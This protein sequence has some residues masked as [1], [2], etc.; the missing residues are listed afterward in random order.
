MTTH[1]PGNVHVRFAKTK[2]EIASA[3]R[4]RFEVFSKE[5]G[6]QLPSEKDGFDIDHFDPYCHHL[7][8][9][10]ALNS[11]VIGTYRILPPSGA[12]AAGGYYIGQHYDLT[13]LHG[14]ASSLIEVGRVCVH[15]DYRASQALPLLWSGLA[16]YMRAHN[17]HYMIG[18]GSIPTRYGI[19]QALNVYQQLIEKYAAPKP[20]RL[21]ALKK[22]AWPT[23][24]APSKA[25]VPP[26]LRAYAQMGAWIAGEPFADEEFRCVDVPILLQFDQL[27]PRFAKRFFGEAAVVRTA[28]VAQS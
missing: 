3:Q 27:N 1:Q 14:I 10:D 11:K 20:L 12:R 19:E 15:P 16:R 21:S 18:S 25:E 24:T 9:V 5:L 6:A 8:A 23:R 4:L 28:A 17:W 2:H 13:P 26:L 7:I 22:L